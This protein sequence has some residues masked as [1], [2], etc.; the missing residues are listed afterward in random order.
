MAC[1]A[2]DRGSVGLVD[3]DLRPQGKSPT[4]SRAAKVCRLRLPLVGFGGQRSNVP[5]GD[6]PSLSKVRLSPIEP[7]FANV[8]LR[9]IASCGQSYVV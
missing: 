3:D 2:T 9:S 6:L 4:W 7:D 5:H 8:M 1:K